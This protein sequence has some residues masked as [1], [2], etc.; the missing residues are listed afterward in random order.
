[1]SLNYLDWVLLCKIVSDMAANMRAQQTDLA[2]KYGGGF[3][4]FNSGITPIAAEF[5]QNLS[6]AEKEYRDAL[7]AHQ[8]RAFH[9]FTTR[10][11]VNLDAIDNRIL[12]PCD[13]GDDGPIHAMLSR[14]RWAPWGENPEEVRYNPNNDELWAA[15]RPALL[16]TSRLLPN[17][18]ALPFVSY[19]THF[20]TYLMLL[21]SSRVWIQDP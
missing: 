6:D 15:L 20:K 7:T 2:R 13:L 16:I 19:S 10:D 12:K 18:H 8:K 4:Y 17:L 11:L 21:Y 14:P 9:G 5:G 1:V 3:R